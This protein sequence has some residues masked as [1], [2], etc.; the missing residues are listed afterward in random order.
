MGE[1]GRMPDSRIHRKPDEPSKQQIVIDLL[2]QHPLRADREE[3]LQQ[4]RPQQHLGR[5]RR[6]SHAGIKTVDPAAQTGQDLVGERAYR[7]QRVIGG[8]PLLKPNKTE[9]FIPA[10][11][12]PPHRSNPA[13]QCKK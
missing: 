10:T 3:G 7:S 8:N 11:T 13:N 12:M 4:R 2:H 1:A 6:T 9:K 5:D